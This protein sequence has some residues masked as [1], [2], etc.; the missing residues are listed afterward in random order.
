MAPRIFDGMF[1]SVFRLTSPHRREWHVLG[2]IS[3]METQTVK[4]NIV[5]F[6]CFSKISTNMTWATD[7]MKIGIPTGKADDLNI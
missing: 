5:S 2:P 7:V 1:L 6:S 3:K 4:Q